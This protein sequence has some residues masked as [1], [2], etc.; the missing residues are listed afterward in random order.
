MTADYF[1]QQVFV[2]HLRKYVTGIAK[3]FTRDPKHYKSLV[4]MAWTRI[5]ECDEDNTFEYYME[6]AWQ[7]MYGYYL[8]Y[9]KLPD[10]IPR[11]PSDDKTVRRGKRRVKYFIKSGGKVDS[12]APYRNRGG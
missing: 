6:Q 10:Y 12:C 11:Y 1:M 9:L 2:P 8:K 7:E 3:S 4:V 5:L